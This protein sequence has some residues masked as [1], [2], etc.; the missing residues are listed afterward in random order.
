MTKFFLFPSDKPP[1]LVSCKK[2][3]LGSL[4]VA[5]IWE[6]RDNGYGV[7]HSIQAPFAPTF[8]SKF[9]QWLLVLSALTIYITYVGTDCLI[10]KRRMKI[11]II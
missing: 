4:V 2:L 11:I 6:E 3:A 8:V 10:I 1:E 5:N 9:G 7:G